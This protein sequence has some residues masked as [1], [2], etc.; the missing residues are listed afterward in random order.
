MESWCLRQGELVQLIKYKLVLRF[1][2]PKEIWSVFQH[3]VP[4]VAGAIQES[5]GEVGT[6]IRA[7]GILLIRE[8][9][10]VFEQRV[11]L[12]VV[13]G[14]KN[15]QARLQLLCDQRINGVNVV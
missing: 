3:R 15:L 8:K 1:V 4:L 9:P 13:C 6:R 11:E 10:V 2:F 12:A 5:P 14:Y 7:I